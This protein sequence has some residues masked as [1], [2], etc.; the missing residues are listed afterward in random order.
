MK[1]LPKLGISAIKI[2]DGTYEEYSNATNKIKNKTDSTEDEVYLKSLTNT[3]MFVS[4]NTGPYIIGRKFRSHNYLIC[5][6]DINQC[7]KHIKITI[8][9][10]VVTPSLLS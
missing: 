3:N 1:I 4:K 10:K 6:R 2:M 9:P 8:F 5:P 7:I